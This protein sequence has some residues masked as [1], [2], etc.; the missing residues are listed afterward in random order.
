[1]KY[2]AIGDVHGC[3]AQLDALLQ[4]R[5]LYEGRR[6][7]F[8][9]DYVDVGP[10]SK[11]VI[12]CLLEF[13]AKH[14]RTVFLMGNHDLALR[15]YLRTG[16]FVAYA[17]VGGIATIRAYCGEVRGDVHAAFAGAIP[18]AH[19]EFL[20]N[21]KSYFETKDY[22]FSHCGYSPGDPLDRSAQSMVLRSH[23]R[24]FTGETPLQKVA[25]CGHYFQRT[26]V[27]VLTETLICLDTGCG[28]L[29]G[30]LTAAMLPERRVVQVSPGLVIRTN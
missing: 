23:Q 7:V 29:S 9:G 30:P 27:A 20:A 3:S 17:R 12:E 19:R 21:V 15:S 2:F 16:D 11:T 6:V 1:M 4:C 8:L 25:V 28:I 24:L 14:P 26:H 10:D 18:A 5:E 22:L 13:K